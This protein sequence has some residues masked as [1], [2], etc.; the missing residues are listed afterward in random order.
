MLSISAIASARW[1]P[2]VSA[3]GSLNCGAAGAGVSLK[4]DPEAPAGEGVDGT[5]AVVEAAD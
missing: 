2:I 1:L 5:A 4:V 3:E